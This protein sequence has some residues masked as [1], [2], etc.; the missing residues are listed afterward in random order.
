[1]P[2]YPSHSF[3]NNARILNLVSPILHP[4]PFKKVDYFKQ[5]QNAVLFIVIRAGLCGGRGAGNITILSL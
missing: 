3:K 1:M 4:C 2:V 5:I